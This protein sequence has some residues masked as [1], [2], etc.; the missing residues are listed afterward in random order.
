MA[1]ENYI[2]RRK[3]STARLYISDGSGDFVINDKP[4]EDYFST[5]ARY[6]IAKFPLE[7][8]EMDGKYDI[9]VT[10]RGG[11]VTGQ[12]GAV[13]L[14]LARAIDDLNED[15]HGILKEN[16]LLTRD[17]R[18][19]ERKKYGQPKARKKFQFSKR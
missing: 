16:G 8:T 11:G 4:I 9:K 14:A 10:V 1:Q 17:D 12:A 6:N 19:V 15:K 18:M 2:G 7:L 13:S 3:T 5:K